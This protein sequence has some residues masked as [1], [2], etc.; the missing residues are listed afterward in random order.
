M[1]IRIPFVIFDPMSEKL[2]TILA[3]SIFPQIAIVKWLANYPAEIERWYSNGI[4]PYLSKSFRFV[5][6]WIPFSVGDIFYTIL[7]I[8]I[9]RFLILKG[10]WFF[11]NTRNF[12]KEVFITLSMAYF[13]FHLFWGMNYYRLPLHEKLGL[14]NDY[15]TEELMSFT[16]RLIEKSNNIHETI[17]GNDTVKVNIPYSR[18]EMYRMTMNGYEKLGEDIPDLSYEPRSIKTSLYSK[19]LTYMGY[20]G[21]LNPFTNEAQVNGLQVDFK[22]PLVSCHEEAHQIGYS[23]E[24][25]ANFVAFL[26]AVRNDDIYFRYSGYIYVLRYCLGEIKRR[27][28]EAFIGLNESINPGIIKNYLEVA[29]F[30]KQH[31]NKAEPLFKNTFNTYLKANNQTE[32]LRSYSYVVAL[33]VNYYEDRP[34]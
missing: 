20:S 30:W 16:Q 9:L 28:P 19:P 7:F 5:F 32:G 26:S 25:E 4:Y 23:A 33:L 10:R 8:L 2:K 14:E 1:P 27:D 22:Y 21:Y 6:G 13:V 34:L 29:R 31:E 3:L 15:T 18:R 17:T 24:N 11:Y 12:F